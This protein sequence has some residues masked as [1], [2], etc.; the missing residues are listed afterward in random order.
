M[1]E[2][3][4]SLYLEVIR[5]NELTN[6]LVRLLFNSTAKRCWMFESRVFRENAILGG[7]IDFILSEQTPWKYI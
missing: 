7:I 4:S 3:H 5:I 1:G 6:A 2:K